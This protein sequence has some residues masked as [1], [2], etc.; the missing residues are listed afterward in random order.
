[1]SKKRKVFLKV[2]GVM[3]LFFLLIG[4]KFRKNLFR[5][6]PPKNLKE[7]AN[8]GTGAGGQ[9]SKNIYKISLSH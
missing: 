8:W 7:I 6:P 5:C 1:L 4:L 9:F 2:M 3:D